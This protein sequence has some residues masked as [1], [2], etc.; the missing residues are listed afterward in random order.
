MP[1]RVIREA[2]AMSKM[3]VI[4]ELDAA[5]EVQYIKLAKPEFLEFITRIAELFFKD[6]ELEDLP[7]HEKLEYLLDDMF[8]LVGAKRVKQEI[9]IE[10]FSD[11][12]D[13]Y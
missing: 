1:K 6:S 3:T 12:D 8:K 7:L 11:S 9:D 4:N 2:F 5:A 13:D 10:E